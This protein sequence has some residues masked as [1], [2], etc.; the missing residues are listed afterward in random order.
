M[1]LWS[2]A[3]VNSMMSTTLTLEQLIQHI[4]PSVG[5]EVHNTT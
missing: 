4:Y 3:V 2:P 5:A 1:S